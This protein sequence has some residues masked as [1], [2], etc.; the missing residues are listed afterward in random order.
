M[1]NL[2][3]DP[4]GRR[5]PRP[6]RPV[7]AKLGAGLVLLAGV[8]GLFAVVLGATIAGGE[9]LATAQ[10]P[11]G[12]T[13]FDRS[14]TSWMVDRRASGVTSVARVFSA[15][16]SGLASASANGGGVAFFA[17][18]GGFAFGAAVTAALL[19]AGRVLPQSLL[20]RPALAS[21]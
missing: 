1:D 9:W 17:H 15:V 6:V 21:H 10:R 20:R 8:V 13:A 11:D 3:H 12:S 16:G 19:N 5:T 14:V 2:A 7:R 18:V 4:A